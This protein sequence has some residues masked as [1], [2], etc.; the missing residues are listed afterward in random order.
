MHDPKNEA[1]YEGEP[2]KQRAS[3]AATMGA[4]YTLTLPK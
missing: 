1:V 4:V 2:L 3:I